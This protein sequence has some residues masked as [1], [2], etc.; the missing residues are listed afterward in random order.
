MFSPPPPALTGNGIGD[1]ENKSLRVRSGK[2]NARKNPAKKK[3]VIL[4]RIGDEMYHLAKNPTEKL[5]D[6]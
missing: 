4:K 5:N 6:S 1:H 3:V 2:R